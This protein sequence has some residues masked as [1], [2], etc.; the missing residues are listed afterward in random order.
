MP[1]S[2]CEKCGHEFKNKQE[3]DN[4][5][6]KV[7]EETNYRR[8]RLEQEEEKLDKLEIKN[9]ILNDLRTVA[10]VALIVGLFMA[11]IMNGGG[12]ALVALGAVT[13]D[14]LYYD[15]LQ[16]EKPRTPQYTVDAN[17]QP[18]TECHQSDDP[19]LCYQFEKLVNLQAKQL[20][21][22]VD[23]DAIDSLKAQ[24]IIPSVSTQL[25]VFEDRIG[26]EK[27]S[28]D[29]VTKEKHRVNPIC[30]EKGYQGIT[31]DQTECVTIKIKNYVDSNGIPTEEHELSGVGIDRFG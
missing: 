5:S 15:I 12:I 7:C 2:E 13:Y 20:V 10:Y 3:R 19:P 23:Q 16:N 29:V 17:V 30:E 4:H 18:K 21:P 25:C 24:L 8:T 26:Y 27:C 31:L 22:I 28:T 9:E 6:W 11:V 1:D 14:V